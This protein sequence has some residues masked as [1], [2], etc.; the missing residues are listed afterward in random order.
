[1]LGNG[2]V[3][4]LGDEGSSAEDNALVA[5]PTVES[6]SDVVIEEAAVTAPTFNFQFSVFTGLISSDHH[7]IPPPPPPP[8]LLDAAS[9]GDFEK[10]CDLVNDGADIKAT[11]YVYQDTPLAVAAYRGHLDIVNF[12]LAKGADANANNTRGDTALIEAS[13]A[14][15]VNVIES[16]LVYGADINHQNNEG[17]TALIKAASR[18]DYAIDAVSILLANGADLHLLDNKG[19]SARDQGGCFDSTKAVLD[20]HQVKI[21]A[22]ASFIKSEFVDK[23]KPDIG[24]AGYKFFDQYQHYS[25][26]DL[27]DSLKKL[28]IDNVSNIFT[29]LDL[30]ISRHFAEMNLI[31]KQ[32][33]LSSIIKNEQNEAIKRVD[34]PEEISHQVM[35]YLKLSDVLNSPK[36]KAAAAEFK[37]H[38]EGI[39]TSVKLDQR[40]RS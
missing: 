10:V 2:E 16:L 39:A 15:R 30:H 28:G 17:E 37:K 9:V 36:A 6:F 13:M 33:L 3:T 35:S 22:L 24:K 26:N 7:Y 23:L 21:D 12:L 18:Y 32:S 1:M 19:K 11:G 34:L 38:S 20:A 25:R 8:P 40:K 5:I 31:S 4:L 14:N 29:Q 27:T